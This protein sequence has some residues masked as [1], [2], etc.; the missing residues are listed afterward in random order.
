MNI[1]AYL[2]SARFG[3]LIG[4]VVISALLIYGALAIAS[5]RTGG[6]ENTNATTTSNGV[7]SYSSED[8]QQAFA[9]S[10]TFQ[11]AQDIADQAQNLIASSQTG[12]LTDTIGRS[13]VI[14]TSAA[15][16]QGLSGSTDAES[17]IVS[18]ALSEIQNELSQVTLYTASD[19]MVVADSSS[20]LHDYAN[21]IATAIGGHPQ[22][23]YTNV[24]LSVGF[25][26]DNNNA[27]TLAQLPATANAYQ[28][29]A[30][31][32]IGIPVP[33]SLAGVQL[34][35]AN[36]YLEMSGSIG[37][38]ET[39]LNDPIRGLAGLQEYDALVSQ[40]VTLYTQIA[41]TLQNDDILF[42]K[43]EAGT[44]WSSFLAQ[45]QAEAAQAAQQSTTQ[46]TTDTSSGS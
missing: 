16:G 5:P 35:I 43:G 34:Q 27:T 22:A 38:M 37:D 11:S 6:L 44:V 25:A 19:L 46:Q 39:V 24:I 3:T 10:T 31:E 42:G 17:Q 23:S 13:L 15:T 12:N 45:A 8:W 30:K 20:S 1:R 7:F 32:I 4:A 26:I 33:N 18:S 2:P 21:A 41:Q 36:N 28:A 9:S 29:L 40:S 14:G